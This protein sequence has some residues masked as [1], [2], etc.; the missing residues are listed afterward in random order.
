[1]EKLD[2]KALNRTFGGKGEFDFQFIG[3]Q[4]E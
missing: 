1:M 4:Q 2:R 3:S